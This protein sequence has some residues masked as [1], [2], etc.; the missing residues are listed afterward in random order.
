MTNGTPSAGVK[1]LRY[2]EEQLH[3]H[4]VYE[5]AQEIRESLD[6]TFT[7]LSEARDKKRDLESRI[8]DVE[9]EIASEERGKHPDMSAAA[10]EK[11]LKIA[12]HRNDD[13]RELREQLS[14]TIG[15]IDGLEFD[16]SIYEV[17]IKIAV[18]R[19]TELGGYLQY[20]AAI[21]QSETTN[22]AIEAHK[23]EATQ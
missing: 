22:K 2:A 5:A 6:K 12:L 10:M 16:K 18:S 17:D 13:W 21:K 11:H 3:V 1:A 15:D 9:M 4:S 20:L 8:V 23:E 19:M 7:G 14:T